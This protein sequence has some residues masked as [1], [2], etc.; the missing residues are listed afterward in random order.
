[1]AIHDREYLARNSRS[2]G[3]LGGGGGMS[4]NAILIGI[5]LAVFA[6]QFFLSQGPRGDLLKEYGAFS[7]YEMVRHLEFWRVLTFQFLHANFWHVAMNMFGL[8]AFGSLVEGYLGKQRYIA[9]YLTSGVAGA[10][11]YMLLNAGGGV[12]ASYGFRG[13]PLLIYNSINTPL[14]GASAGV[15]GVVLAAAHVA[16]NQ[17]VQLFFPPV[18]IRIRSLAYVYLAIAFLNL[19]FGGNNAGGDAAH[20]GGAIAGFVL[21]R[22]PHLLRDFFDIFG[23]SR[24]SGKA[25][26]RAAKSADADR[27]AREAEIDRVLAKVRDKGL[28]S[29]TNREKRLLQ[30]ATIAKRNDER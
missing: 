11:S 20:V 22:H 14:V 27:A 5:N 7:T 13:L 10:V 6:A 24:K 28:P 17:V 26:R 18:P 16:P 19:F 15:F 9:L 2:W 1:M 21:I 4:A 23:D 3:G 25:S 8:Y 30:D 12:A 29:L